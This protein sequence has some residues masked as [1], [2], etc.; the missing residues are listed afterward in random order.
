LVQFR[1]VLR[2]L[3][4]G[5]IHSRKGGTGSTDED[6]EALRLFLAPLA[7]VV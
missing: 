7:L 1:R 3:D 5:I 2:S 6:Q 4:I